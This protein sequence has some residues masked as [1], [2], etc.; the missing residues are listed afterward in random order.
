[1]KT[2]TFDF[3]ENVFLGEKPHEASFTF[4]TIE[5]GRTAPFGRIQRVAVSSK[6]TAMQWAVKNDVRIVKNN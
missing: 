6:E 2:A 3:V 4:V 1:M 5:D